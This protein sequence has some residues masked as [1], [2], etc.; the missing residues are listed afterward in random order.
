[1]LRFKIR[2]ALFQFHWLFGITAGLVLAT[3]GLTGATLSFETEILELLNPDVLQVAPQDQPKLSPME[4][5]ERVQPAMPDRQI[6]IVGVSIDPGAPARLG[7]APTAAKPGAEAN[8]KP[9]FEFHYANPY[10]AELLGSERALRGHEQ[11]HFL[12]DV[13]RKLAAGETGKAITGASTLILIYMCL[14]GL[15]LRW[16]RHAR[17]WR[18]WLQLHWRRKGRHLLWELHT[19]AGTWVLLIYLMSALTGLYWAY[20]WYR[21]GLLALTG[22]PRPEKQAPPSSERLPTPDFSRAW[23]VFQRESGGYSMATLRLPTL[24]G[25]DLQILYLP[26]GPAHD[27]AFSKFTAAPLTGKITAHERYAEKTAGGRLVSSLFPLHSG[28]FFGL[29]GRIVVLLAS[30]TMPL[31]AITGWMLY[32]DRRR[33]KRIGRKLLLQRAQAAGQAYPSESSLPSLARE[34]R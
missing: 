7:F 9:R 4:L 28:S 24:P 31:F 25:Q 16:P 23:A 5:V 15:Y 27:R 19:V 3:M 11:L 13:H 17:N 29:P 14:S 2:S 10:T 20:D 22:T 33:K 21:D 34:A 32:L 18:A 30:L 8:A 1:M 12:E 6:G 26:A